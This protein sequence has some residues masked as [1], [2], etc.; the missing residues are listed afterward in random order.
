MS[1]QSQFHLTQTLY[2]QDFYLWIQTTAQLLKEQ[3]F[4]EVDWESL[5]EE[6]ESMGRRERKELKSRL[7]VLIEHL[8]KLMYWD[9]EKAYNAKE[10]RST[11][12]EQR[13]QIAL[14]LEASPSLRP[15][16][17]ETFLDGCQNAREDALRKYQISSDIFPIEPPF[18]IADV[19][20]SDYLPV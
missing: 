16:L 11:V 17:G 4:E 20:N 18:T 19:L 14:L 10:W 12:V 3:C 15:W 9:V 5:I 1:T 2:E 7:I 13:R 8:L 6:I